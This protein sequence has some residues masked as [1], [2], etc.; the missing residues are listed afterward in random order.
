MTIDEL[1]A[2]T[3][4]TA[5]DEIPI[6]DAE[7]T[8][9]PTKKITAQN[10]ALAVAT[11]QQPGIPTGNYELIS[12][13]GNNI[14][15]A[16]SD[17]LRCI[18]YGNGLKQITGLF[19]VGA[20]GVQDGATICSVPSS[21]YNYIGEK[22]GN[23]QGW[24]IAARPSSGLGYVFRFINASLYFYLAGATTTVPEGTYMLNYL[25]Y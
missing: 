25:Y 7:S 21:D 24:G 1:L 8:G 2:A 14:G 22:N 23:I 11:L 6:W 4:L 17:F 5:N 13:Y 9:E 18:K 20:V 12:N 16:G 19:K 3:S 10:L 15:R